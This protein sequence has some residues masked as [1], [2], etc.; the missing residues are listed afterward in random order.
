MHVYLWEMMMIMLFIINNE[1]NVEAVGSYFCQLD[2]FL[3][4]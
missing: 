3:L 2:T 4:D 1:Q